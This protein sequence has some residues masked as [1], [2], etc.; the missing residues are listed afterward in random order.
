VIL[1]SGARQAG[2]QVN[3]TNNTHKHHTQTPH[4]QAKDVTTRIWLIVTVQAEEEDGW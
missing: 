3:N 2:K 1:V 4:K